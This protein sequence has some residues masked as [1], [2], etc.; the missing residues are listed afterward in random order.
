[1]KC[2]FA[3]DIDGKHLIPGC[4]S[5][6]ISNDI[7]TCTCKPDYMDNYNRF[8]KKE[9]NKEIQVKNEIIKDYQAEIRRL[10]QVIEK[11]KK[12][13]QTIINFEDAS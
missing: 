6:V 10:N 7:E 13:D 2:Y 5:V 3:H 1:M 12:G 8:E 4:W 11:L 9:Y